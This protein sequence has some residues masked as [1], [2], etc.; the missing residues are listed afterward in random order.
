MNKLIKLTLFVALSFSALSACT[1]ATDQIIS[2]QTKVLQQD[3]NNVS[4]LIERGKAFRDKNDFTSALTDYNK[5]IALSDTS[6]RAYL[7][8]GLAYLGLNQYENA[9]TDFTK[10]ISLSPDLGEAYARRGE[11]RV[12]LQSEYQLAL[13]DFDKA[14]S[15]GYSTSGLYR[16]RGQ[17]YVRLGNKTQAVEAFLKA[18]ELQPGNTDVDP[19]ILAA[20]NEAIDL[21]LQDPRLYLQR[22]RLLRTKRDYS[23]AINDFTESIRLN[24]QQPRA[25]EERADAY[26]S[27]GQ[28]TRAQDDL[29]SACRLD[30]RSLCDAISLSC[31]PTPSATPDLQP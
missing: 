19:E 7:G 14:Q 31:S 12:K 18:A 27:S 3:P 8:R 26:Y 15:L 23:D 28:C 11:A 16:Y 9:I 6:A 29:R 13:N 24:A 25:F 22:G 21:N 10:T 17:A 4:A 1:S 5:A 2:T 30:N 20:L